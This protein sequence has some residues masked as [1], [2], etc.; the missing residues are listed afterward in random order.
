M[1]TLRTV[2]PYGLNERTKF[3]NKD[4][5]I[6]KPFPS[7]PRHGAKFVTQRSR[8]STISRIADLDTLINSIYSFDKEIRSNECRKLLDSLRHPNLRKLAVE[9]NSRLSTCEDHLK[10]WYDLGFSVSDWA[11]IINTDNYFTKF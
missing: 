8:T 6:G 2:Y 5:P 7:L 10:R 11:I 3:M 4:S 9:A 1:K